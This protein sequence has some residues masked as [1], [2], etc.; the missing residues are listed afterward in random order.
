MGLMVCFRVLFVDGTYA[1]RYNLIT[2]KMDWSSA[3]EYCRNHK[4]HLVGLASKQEQDALVL[5]LSK[6]VTFILLPTALESN[7]VQSV[8]SVRSSFACFCCRGPI[9][10]ESTDVSCTLIYFRIYA[11]QSSLPGIESQGRR[12]RSMDTFYG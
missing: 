5:H 11:S 8:V 12:P 1:Q 7:V 10:F 2:T 9:V 6:H 4:A 3:A